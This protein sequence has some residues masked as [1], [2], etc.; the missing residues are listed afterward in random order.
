MCSGGGLNET[1]DGSAAEGEGDVRV[2]GH[3][4]LE[5]L[6]FGGRSRWTA[7]NQ[8]AAVINSA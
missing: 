2:A 7:N 4:F 8:T 5:R 1:V 6:Q 3:H